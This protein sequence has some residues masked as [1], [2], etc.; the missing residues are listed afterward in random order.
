MTTTPYQHLDHPSYRP[1]PPDPAG[2]P[3]QTTTAAAI[4]DRY[5]NDGQCWVS[6]SGIDL[7]EL[8]RA[9]C[10]AEDYCPEADATRYELADGSAIVTCGGGWDIG[11]HRDRLELVRARW[12]A[13]EDPSWLP[14]S[15][16]HA[17][18]AS[19]ELC[20]AEDALPLEE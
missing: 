12:S 8:L 15:A 13:C 3:G 1:T 18:P 10:R 4:A 5:H 7:E 20:T 2:D 11:I 17:W 9:A 14:V 19:A 16:A 6:E